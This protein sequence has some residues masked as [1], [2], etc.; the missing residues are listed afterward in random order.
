M[1]DDDLKARWKGQAAD[2]VAVPVE[3]LRRGVT[4]F[5][6]RIALRNAIEYLAC[7]VVIAAFAW[8]MVVFPYPLM[9][10]GSALIILATIVVAWQL[11]VRG[12]SAPLPAD[13]GQRS[14][15][16]FH[17]AQL[18]RQRDAL[19]SVWLW[20]VAPFVPG[21][22]VFR[23]GVETELAAGA[24][25]ARGAWA[26]LSIAAVFV[27]VIALNRY[28]AMRLQRRVDRLKRMED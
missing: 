8:Y 6:R 16:D 21:M 18:E 1:N 4:R 22:V 28:A 10:A 13:M 9:E 5:Q 27:A 20:Y 14:W 2:A 23:W 25:F 11:R 15:L 26:N 19:R 24:P 17:R 3:K 12:A 7:G